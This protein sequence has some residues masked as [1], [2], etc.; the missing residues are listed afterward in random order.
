[1]NAIPRPPTTSSPAFAA[2][3]YRVRKC[4]TRVKSE[5]IQIS[6]SDEPSGS[7]SGCGVAE[8][9]TTELPGK[10]ALWHRNSHREGEARRVHDCVAQ[11]RATVS[12]VQPRISVTD[13]GVDE[14]V[15][16]EAD[17]LSRARCWSAT[18]GIS[19]AYV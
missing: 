17:R 4:T 13:G 2:R 14:L 10:L 18:V 7:L 12:V 5:L 19:G 11:D 3:K 15:W 8:R 6:E 16:W 1:M 9:Q